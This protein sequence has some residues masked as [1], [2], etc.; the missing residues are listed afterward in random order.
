MS[1]PGPANKIDPLKVNSAVGVWINDTIGVLPSVILRDASDDAHARLVANALPDERVAEIRYREGPS[2]GRTAFVPQRDLRDIPAKASR[3][4]FTD[5]A[6]E[7]I[8]YRVIACRAEP[9]DPKRRFVC[10]IDPHDTKQWNPMG[11][12]RSPKEA[13]ADAMTEWNRFDQSR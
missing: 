8:A 2:R 5:W 6:G 1:S 11:H 9:Q 10:E 12:G 7:V 4:T 3:Q 13:L